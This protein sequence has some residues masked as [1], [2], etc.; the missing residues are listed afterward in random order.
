MRPAL[1]AML[2]AAAVAAGCTSPESTRTRG[3]GPGADVGNRQAEV[4]MHAGSDP[5]W[6]T[7]AMI[8]GA[9]PPLDTARHAQRGSR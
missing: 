1:C 5:Y 3:G 8:A 9:H 7:P 6:Q 2:L 4:L